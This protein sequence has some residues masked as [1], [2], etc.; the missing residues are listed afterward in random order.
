FIGNYQQNFLV[1]I[2]LFGDTSYNK[3]RL[4]QLMVQGT[5]YM[6]STCSIHFDEIATKQIFASINQ[7]NLQ[8]RKQ[9]VEDYRILK[10]KL[11]REPL[12]MDFVR[13]GSRD[14]YHY[15]ENAKSYYHFVKSLKLADFV[16]L[17]E[18]SENILS[19][20]QLEVANGIRIGE[21]ILL[22]QVLS[23]G[24]ATQATVT[25]AVADQYAIE[26]T[27]ADWHSCLHNAS[28]QFV[29]AKHEKK[30]I[31][32][33][34]KYNLE[35]FE[36]N[37]EKVMFSDELIQLLHEK[38]LFTYVIDALEY[39]HV[40]FQS[41]YQPQHMRAGF[42]LNQKYTR[43]DVFR[44]LNWETNPVAQNVGGYMVSPD[45][46]NCPIFVT[47]HKAE[48]MSETSQYEDKF[49][50]E[51]VLQWYSKSGRSLQS[52]D[53]QTILAAQQVGLRLPLF[54][55]KN[56]DEGKSFYYLGEVTPIPHQVQQVQLAGK[57]VV[58]IHLQLQDQVQEKLYEYLT[59]Q[60]A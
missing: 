41:R 33:A 2:A 12:M 29:T 20:W 11:G 10:Y 40:T 46:T 6:P 42:G 21:V 37:A 22:E 4:R 53:V 36:L 26:L 14:P 43:K 44:I 30:L 28:L 47:Y 15:V 24:F 1:P 19:G 50:N 31:P 23:Q 49:L 58:Q 3:D 13:F 48:T 32:Y 27:D 35:I 7:S 54:V 51:H 56:D 16:E 8:T 34:D 17:S 60:D 39:A 59:T 5:S 18:I 25:K 52:N 38:D 57:K 55:K 9:L 45:Q